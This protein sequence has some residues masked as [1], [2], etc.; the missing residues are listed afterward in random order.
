MLFTIYTNHK[1]YLCGCYDDIKEHRDNNILIYIGTLHIFGVA[2]L[3]V[4]YFDY[5]LT[6]FGET[7]KRPEKDLHCV[8]I[9]PNIR[10]GIKSVENSPLKKYIKEYLNIIKTSK[11]TNL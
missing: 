6:G 10:R 9:I 8:R 7:L 2:S 5:K 4:K 11:K 1:C 3:L